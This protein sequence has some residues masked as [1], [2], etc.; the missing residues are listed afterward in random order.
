MAT[1]EFEYDGWFSDSLKQKYKE[2]IEKIREEVS[3]EDEGHRVVKSDSSEIHE[4]KVTDKN[5][6]LTATLILRE[7]DL[8]I[9]GFKNKDGTQ[10]LFR[11]DEE[12]VTLGSVQLPFTGGY[13]STSSLGIYSTNGSTENN[14]NISSAICKVSKYAGD[15]QDVPD[16]KNSLAVLIHL[17]SEATRFNSV[18]ESFQKL[19]EF[20]QDDEEVKCSF[21]SN[22][23]VVQKW[24]KLSE[25]GNMDVAVRHQASS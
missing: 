19:I 4:I 21:S 20:G 10:F 17:V 1:Y 24:E 12:D 16:L 15:S 8:Y 13:V 14:H 2:F 6:S 18:F 9:L 5:S 3:K 11:V 22:R 7:K 23:D 25:E